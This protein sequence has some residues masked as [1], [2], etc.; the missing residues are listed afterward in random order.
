MILTRI[1]GFVVVVNTLM[2]ALLVAGV[3][4]LAGLYA[5]RME[6]GWADANVALASLADRASD[7]KRIVVDVV[8]RTD[9]QV[10]RVVKR[11]EAVGATMNKIGDELSKPIDAI[12]SL[13]VPTFSLRMSDLHI[14]PPG[15][16]PRFNA[17]P[18]RPELSTG[19]F[20]FGD[21]IVAPFRQIVAA[22]GELSGPLDDIGDVVSELE[23]LKQLGPGFEAFQQEVGILAAQTLAFGREVASVL[24][25]AV[26]IVA[27]L[28]AWFALAYVLW[29]HGRL[30][31]GFAMM[32]GRATS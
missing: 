17:G 24:E 12:G 32:A 28:L 10:A 11:F 29:A 30:Q 25:V 26:W 2:P 15:P 13:S 5:E 21:T 16:I 6:R 7:S 22:L 20:R 3:V 19:Q 9:E 31:R 18:F 23:R 14:D 27:G 1:R 4:L 8:V